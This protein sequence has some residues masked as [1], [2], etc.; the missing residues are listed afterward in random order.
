MQTYCRAQGA[1]LSALWDTNGKEIQKR[2]G[3]C[4]YI[5]L[6]NFAIQQKLTQC[7][8]ANTHR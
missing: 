4:I 1:L 8:K 2:G 7:C 6:I 3:A 5:W